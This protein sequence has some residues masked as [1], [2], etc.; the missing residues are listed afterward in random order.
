MSQTPEQAMLT[1]QHTQLMGFYN[2][3]HT[4]GAI[5]KEE[6]GKVYNTAMDTTLDM[7]NAA[8]EIE[9]MREW[10][11]NLAQAVLSKDTRRAESLANTVYNK[12]N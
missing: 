6:L 7:Y 5:T 2:I 12:Y 11:L 3:L 9:D 4:K 1:I 8:E 10:M